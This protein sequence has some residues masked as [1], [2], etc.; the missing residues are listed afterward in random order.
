MQHESRVQRVI[1]RLR[2]PAN[3]AE[4]IIAFENL[5]TELVHLCACDEGG[6]GRPFF[7]VRPQAVAR[8]LARDELCNIVERVHGRGECDKLRR[9]IR[10]MDLVAAWRLVLAG[11][12]LVLRRDARLPSIEPFLNLLLD[13]LG[14]MRVYD[15]DSDARRLVELERALKDVKGEELSTTDGTA[16]ATGTGRRRAQQDAGAPGPAPR[17]G[18]RK[19]ARRR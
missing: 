9:S 6:D 10:A 7:M 2:C 15:K 13:D 12:V 16:E 19:S 8:I 5:L 1:G 17:A 18:T 14:R 11:Y 3:V 4:D